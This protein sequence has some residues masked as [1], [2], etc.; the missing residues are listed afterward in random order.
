MSTCDCHPQASG[1]SKGGCLRGGAPCRPRR[2]EGSGTQGTQNNPVWVVSFVSAVGLE[3]RPV[4]ASSG[5]PVTAPATPPLTFCKGDST[6]VPAPLLGPRLTA[7]AALCVACRCPVNTPSSRVC[8]RQVLAGHTGLVAPRTW[9][10]TP[11]G[12]DPP[13]PVQA[14]FTTPAQPL[15]GRPAACL[16]PCCPRSSSRSRP[17]TWLRGGAA[18][19]VVIV[20][21]Q[22]AF[23][24]KVGA[25]APT[26]PPIGPCDT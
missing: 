16:C 17:Q 3:F 20:S 25:G 21:H 1:D 8:P 2:P 13:S 22:G 6:A 24:D 10:P 5:P 26:R 4:P 14:Q 7:A 9:L 15:G 11:A 19:T 23:K 12:R 18:E